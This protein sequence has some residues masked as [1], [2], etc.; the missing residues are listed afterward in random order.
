MPSM[1][2][3]RRTF[4]TALTALG[5]GGML[6][7]AARGE[8]HAGYLSTGFDTLAKRHLVSRLD[9]RLDIVWDLPLPARGHATMIRPGGD[10]ALVVARR[11]GSY[12][13]VFDI[14]DGL[15]RHTLTPQSGRHFYGHGVYSADGRTLWM[16]EN[17]F[18]SGDGVIG[19]YDAANGYAPTA[20]FPSGGIGPHQLA[21]LED[22]RT[23]VVANGG[24]RTH[25]DSGRTKLNL[26]TMQPSLCYINTAT[27]RMF[28]Q[29]CFDDP[30]RHMLSIRHLAV[31]A[32]GTVAF[33][34]QDQADNGEQMPL[35]FTHRMGSG[36]PFQTLP[37]PGSVLGQM[38]GYCGSV[39]Y[40]PAG[41]VLAVS[42]PRGGQVAFW[43]MP[44]G[45]WLDS[46]AIPDGCGVAEAGDH[47]GFVLSNGEG[48]LVETTQGSTPLHQQRHPFRKWDNHLTAI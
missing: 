1:V 17:S 20:A 25:P 44:E 13:V 24:I 11:P 2:I 47:P 14:A 28:E 41:A 36:Q 38:A 45:R 18:E 33:A 8:T 19:V 4:I 40:D 30:A 23:L 6:P 32:D 12:A 46:F 35:V 37:M 39:T 26:E 42:S 9:H 48:L 27:G 29:V 7:G 22:G 34:C 3:D 43:Q 31:M 16:T 15:S 5:L 10:E 21:L